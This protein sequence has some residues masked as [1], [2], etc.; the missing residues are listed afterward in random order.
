MEYSV[1][2]ASRDMI[3]IPSFMKIGPGIQV[4]LRF[5]FR[6]FRGCNVGI[7]DVERFMNYAV[8]MELGIMI[9]IPIFITVG[10]G[11]QKLIGRI[12]IQT[13]REQGD[14]ISLI[15]VFKIRKV[16]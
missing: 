8:E 3:Y 5:S 11:I 7:T 12:H 9:Y 15:Y 14:P 6:N 4:I 2:M 10:S 1:E 16:G 13:R